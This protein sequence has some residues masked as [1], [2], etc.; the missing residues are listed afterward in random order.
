MKKHFKICGLV[1]LAL[2]AMAGTTASHA[3]SMQITVLDRDGKPAPDAVVTVVVA[4]GAQAGA[5]VGKALVPVTAVI[6]QEKMAFAPALTVVPLG[7]T[8]K[9][10]NNDSW[11]HHVRGSAAGIAQFAPP[12]PSAAGGPAAQG[13]FELRIPGKLDAKPSP[14]AEVRMGKAGP[15]LLGCFLHSSMRGNVFVADTPF[16]AKTDANGAVSFDNLPNGAAK[17]QVWHNDQLLELPA[18]NIA[19]TDAPAKV[20]FALQVTPRKRR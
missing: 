2:A 14:F 10:V 3:G 4:S 19:V 20:T 5:V 6:T 18:Q 1:A 15:V 8:L 11:D 7:S 13:G 12:A 9:F 16:A 17:V